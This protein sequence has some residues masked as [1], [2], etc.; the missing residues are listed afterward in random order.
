MIGAEEANMS[1][2]GVPRIPEDLSDDE[3]LELILD[4]NRRLRLLE[5]LL[6]GARSRRENAAVGACIVGCCQ[7]PQDLSALF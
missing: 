3:R 4:L 6:Q 7:L 2:L 1:Q 5:E